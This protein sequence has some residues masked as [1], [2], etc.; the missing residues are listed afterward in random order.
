MKK[1]DL[2]FI[3][4]ALLALCERSPGAPFYTE[5]GFHQKMKR[6]LPRERLVGPLLRGKPADSLFK[7]EYDEV[8]ESAKLTQKQAEVLAKRLEGYTFE[9]IGSVKG[10]TKQSAQNLFV[11]AIKKLTRAFHVYP[12]RGLGDV[13]SSELARG[14]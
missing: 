8:F 2:A 9:E 4:D 11:Q 10:S 13:Y 7:S 3:A 5:L 1:E 6:D 14:K 12:Y